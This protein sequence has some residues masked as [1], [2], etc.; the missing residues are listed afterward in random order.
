MTK[1]MSRIVRA[2]TA[3][4]MVIGLFASAYADQFT[5]SASFNAANP[6][7]PVLDFE[8]IADPGTFLEPAP[9]PWAADVLFSDPGD[10]T[11]SIS[12]AD[13]G[14]S[15]GTPTDVLFMDEFETPILA[16]FGANVDAVGF[17]IAIGFGGLNA[18]VDVFDTGGGLLDSASFDTASEFGDFSTFIGFSNLGTI[19]SVLITPEPG[20]FVLIDNCAYGESAV[21]CT[22][23]LTADG[24]SE[25]TAI[26]VGTVTTLLND[27]GTWTVTYETTGSWFM[28]ETHLHVADDS[29]AIPQTRKGN[30][31]VG[32]FDYSAYHDL[33][34]TF[35]YVVD[36]PDV[37]N[38]LFA[39][40]TAVVDIGDCIDDVCREETAWG[41][42]VSFDGHNWG[43]FFECDSCDD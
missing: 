1:L 12:I 11:D 26:E 29:A 7:L 14:F 35:S 3:V 31:K 37:C 8:G 43:M 16:T 4:T 27:D 13:S 19:G 33:V 5:D 10:N 28:L 6:G 40:H 30:P 39:A 22:V 21:S 41:E 20:G 17:N 38:P 25:D 24:G 36:D 42:G 15:F 2:L 32:Q 9:Q 34:Q 18:T 23:P